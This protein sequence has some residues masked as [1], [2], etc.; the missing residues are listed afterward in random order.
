MVT[1]LANRTFY[2]S[3]VR[4]TTDRVHVGTIEAV[5]KG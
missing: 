4:L 2:G 5:A 1:Q 3:V